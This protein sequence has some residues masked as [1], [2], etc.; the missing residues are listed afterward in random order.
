MLK[1]SYHRDISM[2]PAVIASHRHRCFAALGVSG[3]KD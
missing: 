3:G 1:W 2:K